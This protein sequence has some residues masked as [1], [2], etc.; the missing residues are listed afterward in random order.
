M[1]APTEHEIQSCFHEVLHLALAPGCAL[2]FAICNESNA[3]ITR[4]ALARLRAQGLRP[5]V[6]DYL[7]AWRCVDGPRLLFIE[8]KRPGEKPRSS[9][10][11][12][13]DDCANIGFA[14]RV[15]SSV[16]DAMAIVEREGVPLRRVWR[17]GRLMASS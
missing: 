1:R 13:A 9:Q 5:G 3:P 14:Y 15:C 17:N 6:A 11:A 8:F 16:D 7:I 12:F 10:V 2:A 4:S